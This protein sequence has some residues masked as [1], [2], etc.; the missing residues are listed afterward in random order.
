MSSI[1]AVASSSCGRP[2]SITRPW[3]RMPP[4]LRVQ[5]YAL[6]VGQTHSTPAVSLRVRSI[7][8][9]LSSTRARPG[10]SDAAG[11][12]NGAFV[13]ISPVPHSPEGLARG[14]D[15]DRGDAQ[16]ELCAVDA[17][18]A[19]A[20][21]RP[22]PHTRWH[23]RGRQSQVVESLRARIAEPPSVGIHPCQ[24]RRRSSVSRLPMA[25]A[26]RQMVSSERSSIARLVKRMTKIPFSASSRASRRR[27]LSKRAA[28]PVGCRRRLLR[29]RAATKARR[30]PGDSRGSSP[31]SRA[32]GGRPHGSGAGASPPVG[33][34]FAP[35]SCGRS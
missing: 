25:R 2:S 10:S 20:L 4:C 7:W 6:P 1:T 29:R 14:S 16:H 15:A 5:A 11:A 34:R 27:S 22:P 28:D 32:P 3:A 17:D 18:V 21:E 30:S 9:P 33:T 35:R 31:A 26:S 19:P 24:L 13:E 23:W 12:E 8:T